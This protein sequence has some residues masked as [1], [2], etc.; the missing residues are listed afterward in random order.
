MRRRMAT[1]LA[2]AH[3]AGLMHGAVVM[4]AVFAIASANGDG[5]G[6]L[7]LV[8]TVVLAIYWLTHAYTD[9]L[10]RGIAGDRRH[11]TRRLLHCGRHQAPVV[12]GGLP[13]VLTFALASAAGAPFG[14]AVSLALWLTLALLAAVGYLSAHLAGV[15]G[16]RLVGETAFAALFGAT[17]VALNT[18]LH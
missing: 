11:L 18:L 1:A 4:G 12:L 9:A 8:A 10:G 14:M 3:P 5:Q 7:A 6:K 17:M 16:W 15:D 13:T 2:E